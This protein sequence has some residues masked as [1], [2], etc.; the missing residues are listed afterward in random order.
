MHIWILERFINLTTQIELQ[1]QIKQICSTEMRRKILQSNPSLIRNTI[2][3]YFYSNI[4]LPVAANRERRIWKE[5]IK[6]HFISLH[7]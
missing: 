3:W 4:L 6:Q 5:I 7:V 2:G 1:V